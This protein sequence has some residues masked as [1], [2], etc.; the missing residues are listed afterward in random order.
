AEWMPTASFGVAE[1]RVGEGLYDTIRYA[2]PMARFT[3]PRR[4]DATASM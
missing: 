1:H 4:L 3:K 2:V